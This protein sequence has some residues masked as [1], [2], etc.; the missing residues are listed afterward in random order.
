MIQ[1]FERTVSREGFDEPRWQVGY[2][3]AG[4]KYD[5]IVVEAALCTRDEVV[6][7]TENIKLV[8]ED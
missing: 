3:F 1:K 7:L 2:K 8:E 4:V 5:A 6:H